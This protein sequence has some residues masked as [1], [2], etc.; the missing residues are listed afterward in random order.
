M[1]TKSTNLNGKNITH[2][3]VIHYNTITSLTF[4]ERLKVFLGKKIHI[5]SI[6]FTMQNKIDIVETASMTVIGEQKP[7]GKIPPPK[8]VASE[9]MRKVV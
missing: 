2:K 4:K 6:I 1:E 5:Y 9:P 7:A 8:G 3:E